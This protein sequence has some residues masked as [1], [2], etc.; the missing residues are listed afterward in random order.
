MHLL[1][2]DDR[3][4]PLDFE[5]LLTLARDPERFH[6]QEIVYQLNAGGH[7]EMAL[8]AAGGTVLDL[9]ANVGL[10][11]LYM[12]SLARTVYALEPSP[13]HF[14][15]LCEVLRT[16]GVRNVVPI[17]KAVWIANG[18]KRFYQNE[19]R[20][21]DS[22]FPIGPRAAISVECIRLQ[23]LFDDYGIDEAAL[24]KMDIEGAEVDIL[25]DAGF[26]EAAR[27]IRSLYLECHN[28]KEWGDGDL[29][30]REM[31]AILAKAFPRVQ[32]T[33]TNNLYAT[34]T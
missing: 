11:S 30:V 21:A 3:R 24:V 7:R 28:F 25:R 4:L 23:Q 8:A 27:R 29:L 26:P 6:V 14:H 20:T 15:A 1:L 13:E 18:P 33:G 31:A 17:Q 9:G 12:A 5:P 34:R 16:T 10:F 22:F 2:P 32:Q 19:N